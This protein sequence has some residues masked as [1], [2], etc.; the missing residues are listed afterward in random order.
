MRKTLSIRMP[1]EL[2][3]WI[4]E[5]SRKTGKSAGRVVREHLERARHE[6]GRKRFLGLAGKIAGPSN[7]SS[8]KGFSRS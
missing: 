5:T 6:N 1:T 2:A 3:E 4:E 7:L 8:R